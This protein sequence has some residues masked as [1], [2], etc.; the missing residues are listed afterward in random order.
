MVGA[1]RTYALASWLF[2]RLL[3]IVYF[4]AFASLF[5]QIVGLVGHDGILPAAAYMDAV[6]AF[7]AD[8]HIGLDRFRLFPT[9]TWLNA[10]DIFLRGV[11]AAGMVGAAMLT[12]GI[13]QV[14]VTPLLWLLYLTLTITGQD[15]LSYQWDALLLECGFLAVL[16]TPS[17]RTPPF[18]AVEPPRTARWLFLWLVF[19]LMFGSGAVKLASGDPTWRGL[20]ALGYHFETQPIPTPVAWYIHRLPPIA[21]EA[22]TAIVF[23]IELGAPLLMLVGRR[24]PRIISFVVLVGLQGLIALTGN[25]AFFNLLS[26]A[27]CVFLLPDDVLARIVRVVRVE[28][29]PKPRVR[30]V[31]AAIVAVVT[32]P[33]SVVAFGGSLALTV[34]GGT[35]LFPMAAAVEPFQIV[36][37]YGLFAVMTTTRPEII[38]EGSNDG[39]TWL[40][41]E[42]KYKAG[43]LRR[44]PP[45]VAPHQPRLDWQMWFASLSRFEEERWFG[46]FC[47]RLLE[48]S[49]DVL[50][51]L[52]R[53]PFDGRP[54]RFVRAIT[55]DYQFSTWEGRSTEGLWWVRKGGR[56]YSATFSLRGDRTLNSSGRDR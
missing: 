5:T 14:L 40:P 35:L 3:G 28:E 45:W 18:A 13:G 41:Y 39:T 24:R 27:L 22:A 12:V 23:A 50:K 43:D 7:V 6:R 30:R 8:Q 56:P 44:P 32:V 25:Y 52:A 48:P 38:V 9:L 2:L 20:T 17:L 1:G 21:L 19:R 51:L 26:A 49:P 47:H 34:P 33:A 36:N 46:E 31:V 10:S 29:A 11:C 54:P 37:S 42:F 15:F 53:D 55:Y 4:V 16:L